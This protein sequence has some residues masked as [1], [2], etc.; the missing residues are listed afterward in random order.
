MG[1]P[2]GVEVTALAINVTIPE[3]LRW[4]D[5][6]RGETFMLSTLNIRLL[7]DG[8]LA[9]RAYG[10]PIAGGRGNYVS[11]AVPDRPELAALILAA[12]DR[13]SSRWAGHA[14]IR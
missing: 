10:R 7:S 5:T 14:G 6:R 13:A 11:F 3:A 2:E 8:Q 4:T 1:G 9:A 12:A